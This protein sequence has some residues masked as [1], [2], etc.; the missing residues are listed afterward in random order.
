MVYTPDSDTG[1]RDTGVR[2]S[3]WVYR[4]YFLCMA[5]FITL[6]YVVQL[7]TYT[8]QTTE[9]REGARRW[10]HSP[11]DPPRPRERRNRC[12]CLGPYARTGY[13][14]GTHARRTLVSATTH[15]HVARRGP[16][17]GRTGPWWLVRGP[18]RPV[19]SCQLG[20]QRAHLGAGSCV[21]PCAHQIHEWYLVAST[22]TATSMQ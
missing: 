12:Y 6:Y 1:H 17:R 7:Y 3:S 14:Y 13:A 4:T 15:I 5:I 10:P 16:M 18:A 9:V 11:R 19:S 8:V 22:Y 21:V 20:S 2:S